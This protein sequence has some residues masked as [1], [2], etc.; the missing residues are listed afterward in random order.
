M[1]PWRAS[2]P[3]I[4]AGR[5]DAYLHRFAARVR[6]YGGQVILSFAPEADGG[7]YPWG[8]SHARPAEGRAAWRHV[9]TLFRES[10]ASNVTWLWDI[11]GGRPGARRARYWWPG[12]QYVDWIGVDG[13]YVTRGDTFKSV[14]GDTVR[15][16]RT[17][18]RK[19][20]LVS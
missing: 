10:A 15:S 3:G 14:I 2:M 18:T 17:F 1:E 19:P 6:H 4:A 12:A 20:I 13:S 5:W 8:W 11:S 16:V 7:W 9:V